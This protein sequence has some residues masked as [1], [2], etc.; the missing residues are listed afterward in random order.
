MEFQILPLLHMHTVQPTLLQS[1]CSMLGREAL[2]E[3][4]W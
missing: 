2:L 3:R 1:S 4:R